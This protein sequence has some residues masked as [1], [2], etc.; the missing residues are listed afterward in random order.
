MNIQDI[1]DTTDEYEI[2]DDL[3]LSEHIEW[4]N[5]QSSETYFNELDFEGEEIKNY[6]GDEDL[7]VE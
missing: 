4:N 7:D 6:A 2:M 5:A 3:P 1:I